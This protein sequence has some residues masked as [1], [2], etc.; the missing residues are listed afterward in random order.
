MVNAIVSLARLRG[1]T[2]YRSPHL[3][4]GDD[5][6]KV[7]W[8]YAQ[9]ASFFDSLSGLVSRDLLD[10]K[11]VLDA[12]CGWGGKAV[13]YAEMSR[14]KT[15]H[16]F[17]LPGV[18]EPEA[19]AAF[20]RR[21]GIGNCFFTTGLAEEMPY[22]GGRFDVVLMEDVFE[23]VSDPEKVVAECARVLRPG[24]ILVAKFPSFRMMY[25][26]HLDRALTLPGLHYLLPMKTW[27]AGL[28]HRLL[29]PR[30]GEVYEP[31]D[32]VVATKYHPEITRNLNG[33]HF[34]AFREIVAR[35][36]FETL[37]LALVPFS[38]KSGRRRRI[39]KRLYRLLFDM[40]AFREFLA[41]FVLFV[42][43]R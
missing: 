7:E 8:E 3:F 14:M 34:A 43:R 31:F 24:G 42:G 33:L 38:G 19:S 25:A 37:T 18:Y 13:Y 20:A 41:S 26:H 9:G 4:G 2:G 21:K 32:E 36:L 10:G 29:D 40:E 39:R 12:G 35:S 23:H 1:K 11:E 5:L 17:D 28:N 16:A 22:E 27:A 30:H 6:S 15:I